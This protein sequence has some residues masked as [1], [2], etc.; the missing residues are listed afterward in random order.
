MT[1]FASRLKALT[2][3][4]SR[5]TADDPARLARVERTRSEL[6]GQGAAIRQTLEGAQA[7][8]AAIAQMLSARRLSRIVVVG[9][10]DSWFAGKGVRHALEA[11]T[12]L[13]AEAIEALDYAAY[14]AGIAD[15]A[16]LV[17]GISSGGNTSAVMQALRAASERGACCIGVS[18]TAGSPI[19]TE[20]DAALQVHATR[21]GW[22]TQ[23]TNATMALL[24]ALGATLPSAS[25]ARDAMLRELADLPEIIDRLCLE[26]DAELKAL[27]ERWAPAELVL[28][29]GLGPNFAA[30]SIGAAKLR[31]LSPVH[32]FA[33]PLE[34][35]HHYRTQKAGDPLVLVATDPASAERALDTALV[36]EEVGGPLL[37]I[38]AARA[39][40]IEKRAAAV[41]RVPE[42]LP[43][44]AGMV[45]IVPLHL[46]AYHFARARAALGLGAAVRPPLH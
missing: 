35:Y 19:L 17:I 45:S 36:A 18:N 11:M 12:S 10:G 2:A 3:E 5:D 42:T 34:E 37:A 38:L 39:P 9:C 40:E 23:S 30:A 8:L 28:Y 6:F 7:N 21:K 44:L 16:T 24:I 27:A 14:E 1:D 25:V 46:L 26:L 43:A 13:P 32:A 22:P 41:I 33:L 29:S 31:E 15:V 20:F 4:P